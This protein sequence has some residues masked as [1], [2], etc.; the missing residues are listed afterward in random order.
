M[1]IVGATM[2]FVLCSLTSAGV[3]GQNVSVQLP[4]F[5]YFGVSTTV[6]VPDRGGVLLG[7]VNRSRSFSR[8]SGSPFLPGRRHTSGWSQGASL[9]SAHVWIHDFEAMDQA[10][11][12]QNSAPAQRVAVG[13]QN[14]PG[15]QDLLAKRIPIGEA[16]E[17]RTVAMDSRFAEWPENGPHRVDHLRTDAVGARSVMEHRKNAQNAQ[18]AAAREAITLVEKA[19]RAED[20]NKPGL[21]RVYYRMALRKTD[22]ALRETIAE[23]L[24]SLTADVQ[25]LAARRSPVAAEK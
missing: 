6:S 25:T 18:F 10:L 5:H 3:F 1:R 9:V 14:P 8:S 4:T 2:C 17:A 12:G 22:G 19:R 16:R 13:G 24:R 21:A 11:L 15:R 20:A 7:G 23:R